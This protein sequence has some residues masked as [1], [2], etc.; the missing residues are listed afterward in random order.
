MSDSSIE[1]SEG[2]PIPSSDS[3][4]TTIGFATETGRAT[5]V[6]SSSSSENLPLSDPTLTSDSSR[7]ITPPT[8]GGSQ[9]QDGDSY[10][11]PRAAPSSVHREHAGAAAAAAQSPERAATAAGE[12]PSRPAPAASRPGA[13][14]NIEGPTAAEATAGNPSQPPNLLQILW[15]MQRQQI[16]QQ[17]QHQQQ[18]QLMQQQLTALMRQLAPEVSSRTDPGPQLAAPPPPSSL[19]QS[20]PP[21]G[22][23]PLVACSKAASRS[24]HLRPV[25]APGG[26]QLLAQ[27]WA[28]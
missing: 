14:G 26:A 27:L 8:Q 24:G 18:Q 13:N 12:Q 11:V 10:R 6:A 23:R 3:L 2:P 5:A 1:S 9:G 19:H 17:E 20:R 15:Q 28:V 16:Q 7:P 22:R 4:D 25:R 21:T